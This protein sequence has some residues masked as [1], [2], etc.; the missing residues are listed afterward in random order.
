[1]NHRTSILMLSLSCLVGL[2]A[3]GDPGGPGASGNVLLGSGITTDSAQTLI[4]R[5]VPNTGSFDPAKP[6]FDVPPPSG[7]TVWDG[8]A[9]PVMGLT[10]PYA[11]SVGAVLGTTE[12]KNWRIFAWL[13]ASTDATA[14]KAPATGEVFGTTTFSVVSCEQY[15]GY[16]QTTEKVDVTISQTAP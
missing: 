4:V 7:E 8:V 2:V 5:G 6:V 11:Y 13:S 14:V 9:E 10:F 12:Q 16:C 1:M 15:G 3:C